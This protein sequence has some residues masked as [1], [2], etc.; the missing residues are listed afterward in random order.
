MEDK[1]KKQR[2]PS[3]TPDWYFYEEKNGV[4]KKNFLVPEIKEDVDKL[5]YFGKHQVGINDQ[6]ELAKYVGFNNYTLFKKYFITGE[7]QITY[8]QMR[9]FAKG[10]K[11]D[12]V[13]TPTVGEYTYT[14]HNNMLFIERNFPP[15]FVMS[16]NTD[17]IF[18]YTL[19]INTNLNSKKNRMR[20]LWKYIRKAF[21]DYFQGKTSAYVKMLEIYHD[22]EFKFQR[23][24]NTIFYNYY[25]NYD[26][27]EVGLPDREE[28]LND[29]LPEFD[30]DEKT[31][32]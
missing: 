16:I 1:P 32:D 30:I 11:F 18:D 4:M 10:L 27:K 26:I 20:Y 5:F 7:K 13:M 28:F 29:S 15:L 19:K 14:K 25:E 22:L 17:N 6:R 3:K 12:F 31:E 21:D 8:H 23:R 2:L 24:D 9:K